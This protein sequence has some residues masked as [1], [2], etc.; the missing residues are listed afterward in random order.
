MP[1]LI[2]A[3][4]R[5]FQPIT[6]FHFDEEHFITSLKYSHR[7]VSSTQ[8]KKLRNCFIR[9]ARNS[10]KIICGIFKGA[11][12]KFIG[13]LIFASSLL[14]R[15]I[16]VQTEPKIIKAAAVG[17]RKC[18]CGIE[19][20]AGRIRKMERKSFQNKT[21]PGASNGFGTAH[22]RSIAAAVERSI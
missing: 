20:Q 1:M 9:G 5:K 13:I 2:F 8:L 22:H 12:I 11:R 19:R 14:K 10:Q 3:G 21:C 4:A 17:L 7:S 6:S 18:V 16:M 15:T